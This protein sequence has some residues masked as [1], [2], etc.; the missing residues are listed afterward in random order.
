MSDKLQFVVGPET[1]TSEGNNN[2]ICP[3]FF[4]V[5]NKRKKAQIKREHVWTMR[6]FTCGPTLERCIRRCS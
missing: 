4:G 6:D 5:L 2:L 3:T 1:D